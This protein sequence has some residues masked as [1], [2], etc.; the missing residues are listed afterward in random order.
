MCYS[1]LLK[2]EA[3]AEAWSDRPEVWQSSRLTEIREGAAKQGVKGTA[4]RGSSD[5]LAKV[6]RPRCLLGVH[7]A[8]HPR[9]LERELA[10]TG[11]DAG[12]SE[13]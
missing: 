11:R 4:W 9:I 3:T 13:S 8:K 10:Q 5:S 6:P 2:A 12:R 7:F 1:I